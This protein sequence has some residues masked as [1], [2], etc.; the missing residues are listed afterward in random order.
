[1]RLKL[2]GLCAVFL[3]LYFL[4][5]FAR[6]ISDTLSGK[7]SFT[8]FNTHGMLQVRLTGALFFCSCA[9]AAY[10]IFNRWY[11][12]GWG[13]T[14]LIFLVALLAMTGLRYLVDQYLCYW[15]LGF[16]N[17]PRQVKF[18]FYSLDS[19]GFCFYYSVWGLAFFFF[20]DV[21]TREIERK[22]KELQQRNAELAL[23][24]AQVNPHFLFNSLNNIY[25]LVATRPAEAL[26][27]LDQLSSLM[28]YLLYEHAEKVP[29]KREIGHLMEYIE[30]QKIRLAAP[31]RVEVTLGLENMELLLAP[32]L[33][34]PLIENVF[35][36]ADPS[37]ADSAIK[38][39]ISTA[40]EQLVLTTRNPKSKKDISGAETGLGLANVSR[41]LAL[42]YP[43]TH[44]LLIND[45]GRD[46]VLT[47]TIIV[48]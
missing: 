30:L 16:R 43:G 4:T 18:V 38:I 42:L 12:R 31:E 6:D 35:K 40:G 3:F 39:N 46:F 2:S 10:L 37:E 14:I 17:Y 41:R 20:D 21:R 23:L 8:W 13:T 24:R 25:A 47:L 28:R 5:G 48:S 9:V 27:V 19:L 44:L 1:M 29:L 33:L 7:E 22:D 26:P 15:L 36:H 11:A 34:L 45:E 32:L